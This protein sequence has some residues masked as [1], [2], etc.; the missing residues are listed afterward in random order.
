MHSSPPT[1]LPSVPLPRAAKLEV[2]LAA[3]LTGL[4]L[5]FMN[6]TARLAEHFALLFDEG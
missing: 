1:Q 5:R 6:A 2:P 4:L 3:L